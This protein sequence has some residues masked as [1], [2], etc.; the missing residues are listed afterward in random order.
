MKEL[1]F[2]NLS[3]RVGALSLA[4]VLMIGMS[5]CTKRAVTITESGTED[6]II[7]SEITVGGDAT[8]GDSGTQLVGKEDTT[9]KTES[10][11]SNTKKDPVL[12]SKDWSVQEEKFKSLKGTTIK[13]W[14]DGEL[15]EQDAQRAAAFEERYGI[16]IKYERMGWSEGLTKLPSMVAAGTAPDV[17]NPSAS[18]TL[19]YISGNLLQPMDSY[20]DLSDPIWDTTAIKNAKVDGKIYIVPG[21]IKSDVAWVYYNKTLFKELGL[22]EPYT[23]YKKGEWS[24]DVFLDLA[25]K[26][27]LKAA[28]GVT[29]KTYGAGFGYYQRMVA[30]HGVAMW[31][32]R[33]P[34]CNITNPTVIKGLNT[35]AK[36][37]QSGAA[38]LDKHGQD[39]FANRGVAM[40]VTHY[41][42]MRSYDYYNTMKDEIGMVPLP[43]SSV[44]GKYYK[45]SFGGGW[46]ICRTAKN[47]LGAMAWIYFSERYDSELA[48]KKE[49]TYM[50]EH[51]KYVSEEHEKIMDEYLAK[52]TLIYDEWSGIYG[53][54]GFF[55]EMCSDGKTAEEVTAKYLS[56][57]NKGIKDILP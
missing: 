24:W 23:Y 43:P 46:G 29:V 53:M 25:K 1:N 49:P 54:S 6:Q 32:G 12:M 27:T 3:V 55:E 51:R 14:Y 13:S 57:A 22:T 15:N 28:D 40:M 8:Q 9:S 39:T 47:P 16:K 30:A 48:E 18:S 2:K 37:Y 4:C 10:G 41:Q 50:A 45:V 36:F 52:A 19:R 26:T 20:I 34:T 31:D 42:I 7:T 5:G 21:D 56:L 38:N 44:D 33:S 35:F 17:C 11:S